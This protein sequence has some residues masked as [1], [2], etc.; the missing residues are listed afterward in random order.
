V[1]VYGMGGWWL[2]LFYL[3]SMLA[4]QGGESA[5]FRLAAKSAIVEVDFSGLVNEAVPT[6]S[7]FGLYVRFLQF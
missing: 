5:I 6:A 2:R 7:K 4:S 3:Y 1:E